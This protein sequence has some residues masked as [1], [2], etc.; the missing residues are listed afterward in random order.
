MNGTAAG[1]WNQQSGYGLV[2]AINAINAVDLLRVVT[3]N[4]ANG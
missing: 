4:P 1:S 2:N 3:T